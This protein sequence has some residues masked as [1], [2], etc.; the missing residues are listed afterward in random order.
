MT[1][2]IKNIF[3]VNGANRPPAKADVL[4]KG[5]KITAIG[6]FPNY[7]AD[8]A[9]EGM[10]A[11][12]AP[13]FIDINTASDLYLSLFTEPAQTDFIKQGV[14]TIIGG[15][16]G[17][18]LAPLFYGSLELQKFWTN[19]SKLN[20]NWHTVK[21]FLN[22]VEKRPLGV[23]FGILA[24]HST[25]REFLAGEEFRDLTQKEIDV[26]KDI[27]D[28]SLKQGAFGFSVDLN[29]PL[30][31]LVSY[32]ELKSLAEIV[33]ANRGLFS[34]KIRNGSDSSVFLK[35]N[36]DNFIPSVNEIVNLA[37]ETAVKAEINNF[38]CPKGFEKEYKEGIKIIEDNS[39]V[40]DVYFN[41]HPFEISA[42][43]LFAFLPIWAQRGSFKEIQN[44][45][46]S[47]ES[48]IKIKKDLPLLKMEEIKIFRAPEHEYLTGKTLKSFC[49]DRGINP[50]EGLLELMKLTKLRGVL[51]FKNLSVKPLFN[52]LISGKSIVS[53][54]SASFHE[55]NQITD[56]EH[57]K[58]F[59][60]T[61]EFAAKNGIPI[62]K[63]IQKF[64]SLPAR[65][66]G[67]KDRGIIAENM[68]AD[69]VLIRNSKIEMVM[70]NGKFAMKDGQLIESL[71]GKI[72]R[73]AEK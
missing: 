51:M 25:L 54:S 11:Y 32:K 35:N 34:V 19:V 67:I 64:T 71:N 73:K 62:E 70:V 53:S 44:N 66:L 63:I 27:V 49:L 9:V 72:L 59:P 50:K 7:K 38:S 30:T 5:E 4:V 16:S 33:E 46:N 57:S 18:S 17:I 55:D 58:T 2:L 31:S 28:A 68:A 47:L 60:K 37:K 15:Q 3:L 22:T 13:G 45:F 43:P 29:F 26:F 56:M 12:L 48:L 65:Q 21:E 6:Y 52:A 41:L 39:A 23:N 40:S 61:L 36:K 8:S 42:I 14:T 24:G 20:V 1:T 69:L 10:G